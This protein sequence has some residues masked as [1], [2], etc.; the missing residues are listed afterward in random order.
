MASVGNQQTWPPFY[1][2]KDCSQGFCTLYCPQWCYISFSPPPPSGFSEEETN[3]KFSPLVIA[4]IGVLATAF[5]LLSYYI[6]LSKCCRNSDSLRGRLQ[7]DSNEEFDDARNLVYHEVWQIATTGL[8]EALIKSIAVCKYKKGDGFV[9][10][11]D[12]AVCLNEFREDESLRLL[13]KCCHA[14]HLP[15]IDTWLRSHSNCPLC[16]AAIIFTSPLT[17]Q[18]PSPPSSESISDHGPSVEIQVENGAPATID[19]LET[20]A[21]EESSLSNNAISK[22][23]FRTLSDLGSMVS[24]HTIIEIQENGIQPIRRSV[25][26]D[27]LSPCRVSIANLLPTSMEGNFQVKDC[28]FAEGD[29]SVTK[30]FQRE[31]AESYK[32]SSTL[33]FVMSPKAMNRP[34]SSRRLLFHRHGIRSP[35]NSRGVNALDLSLVWTGP[36]RFVH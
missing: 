34:S 29:G 3:L 2:S 30:Q 26:M 16:R 13:P 7:Q 25:S 15:C 12:C 4:V 8:D 23:P 11:T 33:D 21:R 28:L 17:L 5:F 14:F 19:D 10:G 35:G 9:E 20:G 18:S 36:N 24:R 31:F 1:S 27:S 22:Y 32:R 6:L